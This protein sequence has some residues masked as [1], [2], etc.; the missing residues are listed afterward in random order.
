M[1]YEGF[2]ENI[3]QQTL[4]EDVGQEHIIKALTN[5]IRLTKTINIIFQELGVGKTCQNSFK[6]LVMKKDIPVPIPCDK[7]SKL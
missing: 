5:G 6:C 3:D 7:C 2:N 1:S 4:K